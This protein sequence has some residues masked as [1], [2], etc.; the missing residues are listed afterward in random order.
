MNILRKLKHLADSLY[1]LCTY[2]RPNLQFRRNLVSK[3]SSHPTFSQH[4]QQLVDEGILILPSYYS[5]DTLKQMQ[6]DFERWVPKEPS[7]ENNIYFLDK[8][9]ME[10]SI[11]LSKIAVT[12]YLTD[13][14]AYYWG[15]PVYLAETSGLRLEPNEP[16]KDK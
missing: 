6:M 5:G 16:Y 15:K 4:A 2:G 10:D 11:P 14:A 13:L 12:P 8:N 7:S 3:N 1:F 9:C